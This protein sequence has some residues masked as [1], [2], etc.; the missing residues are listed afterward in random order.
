MSNQPHTSNL[1]GLFWIVLWMLL[2]TPF[3]GLWSFALPIS[4]FVHALWKCN[5]I[6]RE[7]LRNQR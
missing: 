4:L 2:T 3:I 1:G 5:E 6:D 7:R